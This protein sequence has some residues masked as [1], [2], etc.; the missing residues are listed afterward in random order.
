MTTLFGQSGSGK[1][2]LARLVTA[3]ERPTSGSVT[4]TGGDQPVD[5]GS[6]RGRKL[7]AY[8]RHAQLVFQDPFAALNPTRTLA[9]TLSRPL[10]NHLGLSRAEAGPPPPSSWRRSA[11]H[12]RPRTS[13]NSRTNS[14]A[15]NASA[16]SSPGPWRRN[17]RS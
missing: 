7:R 8:R 3:V 9:Y 12:R 11:S 10:Q 4:F 1:T 15:A 6:L 14:P 2:T 17:P 13:T 16:S 5:V